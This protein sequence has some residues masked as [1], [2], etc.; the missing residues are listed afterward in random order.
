MAQLLAGMDHYIVADEN[1][2]ESEPAVY[3]TPCVWADEDSGRILFAFLAIPAEDGSIQGAMGLRPTIYRLDLS[4]NEESTEIV[5]FQDGFEFELEQ[6]YISP[7]ET[8]EEEAERVEREEDEL[9]SL[10]GLEGADGDS[11]D[12]GDGE[13]EPA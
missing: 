3:G 9:E 11:T 8:D 1:G 4:E 5:D 13:P 2:N 6:S 10:D 12:D 7:F